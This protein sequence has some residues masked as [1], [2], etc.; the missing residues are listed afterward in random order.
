RYCLKRG[1]REEPRMPYLSLSIATSASVDQAWNVVT[2]SFAFPE[3]MP[4]V[5]AIEL[6]SSVRHGERLSTWSV[7]LED[8]VLEWTQEEQL[9]E[10]VHTLSFDQIEGDLR[11]LR[12]AWS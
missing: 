11:E 5:L 1:V 7:A 2:D 9:D 4:E 8:A 10:A 12:G 6:N 3:Y